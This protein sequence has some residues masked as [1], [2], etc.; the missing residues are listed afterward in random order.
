MHYKMMSQD[1]QIYILIEEDYLIAIKMTIYKK[2]KPLK[3]YITTLTNSF[4]T[5]I[6][7]YQILKFVWSIEL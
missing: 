3:R 7:L 5:T 1:E 4:T 6:A 2:K